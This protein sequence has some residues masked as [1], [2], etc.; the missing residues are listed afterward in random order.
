MFA[1]V[2]HV[3]CALCVLFHPSFGAG[4]LP[5]APG[6]PLHDQHTPAVPQLLVSCAAG[7]NMSTLLACGVHRVC[8]SAGSVLSY[9]QI[10][11]EQG[12]ML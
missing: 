12:Y 11:S 2:Y 9:G 5:R 6:L 7:V 8:T 1:D 3:C 4:Q 10:A